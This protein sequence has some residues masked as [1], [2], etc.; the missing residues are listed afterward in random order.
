MTQGPRLETAAEIERM[1]RDGCDIVGMTSMP[2]ASLARERDMDYACCSLVVNWAAGKT[3]EV[4]TM[5]IIE[6]NLTQGMDNI[7]KLLGTA[8]SRQ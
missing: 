7:L 1:Q 4:I 2:E 3:D 6:Q 8:L 5:D